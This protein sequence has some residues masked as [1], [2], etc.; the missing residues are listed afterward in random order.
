MILYLEWEDKWEI[1]H[2]GSQTSEHM[3]SKQYTILVDF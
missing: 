3:H 2:G 1:D